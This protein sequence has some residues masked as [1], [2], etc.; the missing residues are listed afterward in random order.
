MPLDQL[1]R[2]SI[3]ITTSFGNEIANIIF[4]I[5]VNAIVEEFRHKES[6]GNVLHTMPWFAD[7]RD[8]ISELFDLTY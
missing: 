1:R 2:P 4:G 6:R 7:V 5:E 3:F 8:M